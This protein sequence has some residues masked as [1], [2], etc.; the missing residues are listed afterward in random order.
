MSFRRSYPLLGTLLT[1]ILVF[2]FVAGCVPAPAPAAAPAAPAAQNQ[3]AANAAAPAGYGKPGSPKVAVVVKTLT[4]DVYQLK[5]AEAA[6]DRAKALGAQAEIYQAGGQTAVNQM[7]SIIEDLI[8]KKVDIILISP[9]D[10]KAVGPAFEEAKKAGIITVLMDQGADGQDFAT[11]IATD[12]YKA[13]AL[14]ADYARKILSDKGK[15]LVVEG[16]PGSEAGDRRRDGFKENVV[17]GGVEIVGSQ[18]G[19]WTTEG[20]MKAM[21]NML[22]A[23]PDADLVYSA[24]DVMVAGILEAIKNAGKEGK[25]KVLSFDGSSVGIQF[26]KDGKILSSMAQYP[27]R[28]GILAADLGLGLW[29]GTIDPNALPSYIDTGTNLITKDNADAALKDSF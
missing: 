19:S 18:S 28:E 29:H 15:V 20:A 25:I 24:S 8:Q 22:Q 4:G 27:V 6:R 16:A 14:A 13:G 10:R 12:N 11:L 23:H 21:E 9:L 2:A 7:V 17:K 5:M 26:I 1:L 3:P